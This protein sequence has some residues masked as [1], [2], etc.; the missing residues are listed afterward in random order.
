MRLLFAILVLVCI[1]PVFGQRLELYGGINK[2]VFHDKKDV[3]SHY[4]STYDPGVGFSAG[5]G[6]DSILV[7]GW[8]IRFT[9]HFDQFKGDLYASNG[10][11][12]GGYYTTAS[13]EKS[14]LSIGFFPLNFRI[15]QRMDLNLG[16]LA[17]VLLN[18][19]IHGTSGEWIL[20]QPGWNQD[21]DEGDIDFSAKTYIGLQGRV[22]YDIHL[23][24][25]ISITPQ[26]L[27][28]FGLTKE[29]VVF[30]EQTK[31]MRHYFCIG[32]TKLL[33]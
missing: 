2:N 25:L 3:N 11:L 33:K 8:S 14:T 22:T 27:Y 9:L 5:M 17:S 15:F 7:D 19:S 23:S 16:F 4:L 31:S 28:Y 24:R 30:P 6:I 13:V 1:K 26:Y 29:F 12:G 20:G 32:I 10:A 21:F 18:E